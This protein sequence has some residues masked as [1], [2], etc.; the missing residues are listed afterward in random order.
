MASHLIRHDHEVPIPE[1]L[2]VLVHLAVLQPHDLLDET[3]LCVVR[4]LLRAGVAHVEQLPP[5][6]KHAILITAHDAQTADL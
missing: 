5:E 2:G 1:R 3:D 4:D 6:R